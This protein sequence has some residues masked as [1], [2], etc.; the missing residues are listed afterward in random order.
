MPGAVVPPPA[1]RSSGTG[2]GPGDSRQSAASRMANAT[3][4]SAAYSSSCAPV[5]RGETRPGAAHPGIEVGGA[6]AVQVREE[7]RRV[8]AGDQGGAVVQLLPRGAEDPAHPARVEPPFRLAAMLYQPDS[9]A[10]R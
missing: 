9:A 1:S 5:L 3:P 2:A 6:L 10:L 8:L 4:S 7:Q